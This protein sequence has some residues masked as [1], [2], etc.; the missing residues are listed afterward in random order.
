MARVQN[1]VPHQSIKSN[2]CIG[3]FRPTPYR[4]ADDRE[5]MVLV[6]V[7]QVLKCNVGSRGG[8]R[9]RKEEEGIGEGAAMAAMAYR[10]PVLVS[11]T[12]SQGSLQTH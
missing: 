11:L 10:D 3:H 9:K 5:T 12:D 1:L 6:F 4:K 8:G 2:I 7:S